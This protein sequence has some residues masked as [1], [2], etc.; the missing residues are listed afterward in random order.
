MNR[1]DSPGDLAMALAQHGIRA[2]M[3]DRQL[4]GSLKSRAAVY[5]QALES[6]LTGGD[7]LGAPVIARSWR[8]S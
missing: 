5:A 6:L 2:V 8:T 1:I 4:E 3:L 7:S